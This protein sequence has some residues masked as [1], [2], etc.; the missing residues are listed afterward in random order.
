MRAFIVCNVLATWKRGI[1]RETA[2][3]K[4]PGKKEEETST[5]S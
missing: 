3:H 1:L 2:F 4:I 5:V